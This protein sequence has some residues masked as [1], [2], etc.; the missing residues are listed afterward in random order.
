MLAVFAG[1]PGSGKSETIREM[2]RI[3]AAKGY[4]SRHITI[5][6]CTL[7]IARLI[8]KVKELPF[9]SPVRNG[10][11]CQARA[12]QDT[13]LLKLS[14][15]LPKEEII[16]VEEFWESIIAYAPYL[17]Q[18]IPL[19]DTDFWENYPK[20]FLTPVDITFWIDVSVKTAFKRKVSKILP[21]PETADEISKRFQ[22]LHDKY[23]WL[24]V[25]GEKSWE[26]RAVYC[27]NKILALLK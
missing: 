13:Y 5:S 24:R 18:G 12:F 4:Q 14:Y 7:E 9:E 27:V 19:S 2:L 11:Y 3:F 16:L 15:E 10:L 20:N 23:G 8:E 1:L 17:H 21:M 6:N 25:D 22:S 26:N